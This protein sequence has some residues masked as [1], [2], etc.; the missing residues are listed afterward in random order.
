MTPELIDDDEENDESQERYNGKV[1]VYSFGITLLYIVTEQYPKY[2]LKQKMTGT[3]LKIPSTVVPW[4]SELNVRCVL[5]KYLDI[6]II[7]S[8]Q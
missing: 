8:A 1:D 7:V 6:F 4:V 3:M 5:S 2:T